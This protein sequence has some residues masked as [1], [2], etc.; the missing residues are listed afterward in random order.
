MPG[1]HAERD[2]LSISAVPVCDILELG[3]AL[4]QPQN[5]RFDVGVYEQDIVYS[6]L[7]AKVRH[8]RTHAMA[9]FHP[10]A[11]PR[12]LPA[13]LLL[14]ALQRSKQHPAAA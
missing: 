8:S 13:S 10:L 6:E 12:H 5:E 9:R 11:K 1:H 3:L 2:G 14:L 4:R 7:A